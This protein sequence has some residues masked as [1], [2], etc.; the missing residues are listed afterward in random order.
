MAFLER[1]RTE[2]ATR[3]RLTRHTLLAYKRENDELRAQLGDRGSA[4][5]AKNAELMA[6]N[7]AL[8]TRLTKEVRL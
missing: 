3:S 5:E 8:L 7:A 6:E 1:L 2:E 4:L